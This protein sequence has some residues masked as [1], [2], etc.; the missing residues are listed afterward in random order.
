MHSAR[1]TT[2]PRAFVFDSK[3]N[4]PTQHRKVGLWLES[5]DAGAAPPGSPSLSP[6]SP[7]LPSPTAVRRRSMSSAAWSD[8]SHPAWRPDSPRTPLADITPLVVG[9]SYSDEISPSA[10]FDSHATEDEI[11]EPAA[12]RQRP[13]TPM[14]DQTPHFV[15]T[16]ASAIDLLTPDEARHLLLVSAQSNMSVAAAIK[17]LALDRIRAQNRPTPATP[18]PARARRNSLADTIVFDE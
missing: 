13:A 11:P 6:V 7:G 1:R 4:K 2:G 10:S 17:E 3:V 12:M 18:G 16:L 9:A 5:I 14:D 15:P 8:R